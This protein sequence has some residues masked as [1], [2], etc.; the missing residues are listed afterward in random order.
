MAQGVKERNSTI[1]G[2]GNHATVNLVLWV[3]TV[4]F[5][6]IPVNTVDFEHQSVLDQQRAQDMVQC[7]AIDAVRH[8][9][10]DLPKQP[11]NVSGI[12]QGNA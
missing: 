5:V 12:D 8:R 7:M 11:R 10:I 4:V 3:L 1:D 9:F 2:V 6:G